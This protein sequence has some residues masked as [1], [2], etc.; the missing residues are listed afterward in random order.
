MKKLSLLL[1]V[2]MLFSCLG[3]SAFAEE[4][5]KAAPFSSYDEVNAAIRIIPA[6]GDQVELGYLD[7]ITSILEVDGLQFKDL[8]KNGQLDVYEDWRQ[9]VEAR[10]KDL[11][12][13]MTL[14]ERA[15]LFYHVNTCGNPAGVD[16]ADSGNM[17]GLEADYATPETPADG[18]QANPGFATKSMWYYLNELNITTHLDNTNGTPAQQTVYHN[19]MQALG[20]S[21]RL[22][23]PVVISNDR[24]YN[25]W[26]GMIDTAHD[27]FG[28]ANDLELSKK[29][30]TEYSLESRAVGIHIVLHPYSQELGSWNGEDPY[31]AGTMTKE[32]V[33]AI[34]VE[35]G[36]EA[37]MKH[38]IARGGDS[39]FQNA[40]SDAQTVDNWMTAWRIALESNPKWVMTNGYATGLTNTVHVDYD[41][42]TMDYLRN[43]LGFDGIIVSDWGDQGDNN[44]QGVTVD[45][46]DLMTLTIPE[47]YAFAINLGLDQIGNP[48]ADYSGDGHQGTADRGAVE[49]AITDGLI[50]EERCWETC[51]RVLKDKFELGL[52]E[53]PYSDAEYAL[54]LAASAEFIASPWDVVD[55]DTLMAARNPEVVA[56]ERQLQAESAILFKNDDNLL[57][58][59]KGIKVYIGSTASAITLE[60]YKKV[61]PDYCELVEEIEEAD[62]VIADC[63]QNNDAAEMIIED[64]KDEGKKLVIVANCIDPD[65]AMLQQGD[66][67]LGL[68]FSRGADHGTGAGGFI[69]TTEPIVFAQ[70]LFGEAEPAG[71]VV[72][73]LARDSAMD[74]SQWKDLAGDQGAN[75]WV[76]MMLLATMKTSENNTVPNNWGDPLVQYQYGMKYGAQPEFVYDALVL[77]RATHEVVTESNGSTQTS[78][79][80]VIETKAGEPFTAYV[81]LWNNG[82]AG[83]TTVKATCDGE[84]IAEKIMAVNGGSW[85]VVEMTLTVDQPGE[86]VIT[87]GD[88]TKTIQITE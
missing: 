51:R 28:A 77:P 55:T 39:S 82:D 86:H 33:A 13:Q 53:N 26:G 11:Y 81:L 1:A 38:F 52:F 14:A 75:Q 58:L 61:L 48:A 17:F 16:F 80:S 8:N 41:K 68:T 21:T 18:P 40:R 31:Y 62:V 7:G 65:T 12:D 63:T 72:K 49:V 32:E 19:A 24:Q 47:R 50:S 15:G 10:V 67:V 78:Y 83:I 37:C 9:D 71:M 35:G 34:Q 56:M 22:G 88:L 23:V 74:N 44:S 73:E 6:S 46:L 69:T 84:V 5:H 79:E 85:R 76:R 70:L 45:G 30:W 3:F 57:P 60:G 42:E 20:E 87:V 4:E 29:L 64:A 25:A 43:T 36:T 66:A 27:A 59:E 54:S 2:V